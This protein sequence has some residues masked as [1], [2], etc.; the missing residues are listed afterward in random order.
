MI[1]VVLIQPSVIRRIDREDPKIISYFESMNKIGSLLGDSPLEPNYGLLTIAQV[2]R[3][4]G[5]AVDFIDFTFHDLQ[6]RNSGRRLTDDDIKTILTEHPAKIYGIS[7]MTVTYGMWAKSISQILRTIAPTSYQVVG[8]IHPSMDGKLVL[9]DCPDIDFVVQG[10]AESVIAPLFHSLLEGSPP[11]HMPGVLGHNQEESTTHNLLTDRE[12]NNAPYPAYDL[13][14]KRNPSLIPRIYSS[15]G[16]SEK[17]NFCVVSDFF[18]AS[19]D[20]F[21]RYHR[22]IEISTFEHQLRHMLSTYSPEIFCL[23]DLTFAYNKQ[24]ALE[25][26]KVISEVQSDLGTNAK[27]WAQTCANVVDKELALAMQSAGCCQIA[28]GIEGGEDTQ[29]KNVVKNLTTHT[30]TNCLALLRDIGFEIQTYWIIGLPR[31]NES[32]VSATI[33]LMVNYLDKQLT[34]LTHISILVPYPGTNL[35]R[36]PE[37]LGIRLHPDRASD[38]SQYWMNCDPYGCG[39]PIYSTIDHNGETILSSERIYELW[40]EAIAQAESFYR[41]KAGGLNVSIQSDPRLLITDSGR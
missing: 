39:I 32:S 36:Y 10:E 38:L 6:L 37:Q 8:G 3:N 1:D 27:W 33:D 9:Q 12:M 18:S 15:R 25:I 35:H 28:I 7:Y 20:V 11:M 30:A 19:R 2:L 17:C 40:L 31:D 13:A 24:H 29:R 34:H 41:S 14:L 22:K 16:C 5:I 23:G 21:G 4:S 26:C